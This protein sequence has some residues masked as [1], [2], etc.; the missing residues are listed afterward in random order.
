M[1]SAIFVI[2]TYLGMG[3]GTMYH[4]LWEQRDRL[5]AGTQL[6]KVLS[7]VGY[8]TLNKYHFA[9]CVQLVQVNMD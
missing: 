5:N 3:T 7:M 4:V 9:L 2:H 1:D 8:I 6:I